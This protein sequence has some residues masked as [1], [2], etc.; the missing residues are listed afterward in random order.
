MSSEHTI[1]F[2]NTD[3]R[4]GAGVERRLTSLEVDENFFEVIERIIALEEN[5][6]QPMEIQSIEVD[7]TE[8]TITLSDGLTT[9]GPFELP[10]A[11][12]NFVGDY[13]PG[14]YSRMDVFLEDQGMYLVLEDHEAPTEFN[15]LLTVG[16][17]PCYQLIFPY[18]TFFLPGFF[19]PGM[20]GYGIDPDRPIFQYVFDRD[21]YW[22]A[23][24]TEDVPGEAYADIPEDETP[25]ITF[26]IAKNG[27]LVG[28]L[29]FGPGE[30]VGVFE[31]DSDD[32]I[33]FTRGDRLSF[34]NPLGT[35][36]VTS[37]RDLSV[38]LA[39]KRGTA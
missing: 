32:D 29:T 9:F 27:V 3:T 22:P 1:I 36:G 33:Q 16:P 23:E 37:M 20:P 19:V 15:P 24:T 4:W 35:G 25:G 34:L 39:M 13:A 10:Q 17:S 18:P 5:P 38:T 11:A 7:G 28:S 21:V 30:N 8:M 26:P 31:R 14:E 2:K 12:F 6:I